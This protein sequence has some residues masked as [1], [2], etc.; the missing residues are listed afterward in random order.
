MTDFHEIDD[1]IHSSIDFKETKNTND[2]KSISPVP[3][4]TV[5]LLYKYLSVPSISNNSGN[6][7]TTID[8]SSGS[9][10]LE[11]TFN[12]VNSIIGAGILGIPL[13]IQ[14]CGLIMGVLLLSVVA[15]LVYRSVLI[16]I[17]CGIKTGKYDLEELSESLFGR[18]G[19]FI[20]LTFMFLFAYGGQIAY[21]IIIGDTIPLIA[22]LLCPNTF[23]TNRVLVLFLF[24]SI[25]ILPICLL[26]SLSTLAWTSF[27]SIFCD[28]ILIILILI[29]A[30]NVAK[31]QKEH[32]QSSN[33][34]TFNTSLFTGI[35]TMSF[36]FV[37]QHN[38]FIVYR[39]LKH[40]SIE[41]W[42][43]VAQYSIIFSFLFCLIFGLI[44]FFTF[45]PH[46][47]GDL[48]NNYPSSNISICIA[49]VM[50]A[51]SMIFT[52]PMECYVS[53]HCIMSIISRLRSNNNIDNNNDNNKNNINNIHNNNNSGHNVYEESD[54]FNSLQNNYNH[55]NMN[56]IRR[57]VNN[58]WK[59]RKQ[60]NLHYDGVELIHDNYSKQNVS[61]ES[62]VKRNMSISS[63]QTKLNNNYNR[64]V[65]KNSS[66]DNYRGIG[67]I[68]MD[69]LDDL[70]EESEHGNKLNNNNY[71]NSNNY[72]NNNNNYNNESQVVNTIYFNRHFNETQPSST[73]PM[74]QFS[75]ENNE[76]SIQDHRQKVN[77]EESFSY[78]EFIIITIL[79]WGSTL[80][81][82][83]IAKQL[84]IVSAVT[85]CLAATVLGYILPANIYLKTYKN[86]VTDAI[87]ILFAFKANEY[88]NTS[89]NNISQESYGRIISRL[90]AIKLMYIPVIMIIFGLVSM[91]V[92]LVT[93]F[94]E[95]F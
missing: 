4:G 2:K 14:Q 44:G 35:G 3:Q 31:Q 29:V 28:F 22:E 33:S 89:N 76:V 1:S 5:G 52:Y 16:L 56:Y 58:I 11:A 84:G 18:N 46:V 61:V 88:N 42:K 74:H 7:D 6:T 80:V 59:Q 19:Y 34:L 78:K 30:P 17:E 13:A 9:T 66:H 25:I 70:Y 27:L 81:I 65:I 38:S 87:A 73:S 77:I 12:F 92:G 82:A 10:V 79:L 23:L 53:R 55:H 72:D 83:I 26:K 49:R 64:N 60:K 69:A 63:P 45:Y 94:I 95:Y 39:S 62:P 71:N 86:E 36:A 37:C 50:I 68:D 93:I 43:K 40:K 41:N 67:V 8:S 90:C 32:F 15:Y 85:G 48:L 47:Q 54:H 75:D 21:L 91:F 51:S 57:F 24:S 20:A